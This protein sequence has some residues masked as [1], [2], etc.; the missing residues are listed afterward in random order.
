MFDKSL[1]MNKCQRPKYIVDVT[2]PDFPPCLNGYVV[3]S[4]DE[5]CNE[6]QKKGKREVLENKEF[7][8]EICSY[9]PD[10][11]IMFGRI[12]HSCCII[13]K[14]KECSLLQF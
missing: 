2:I 11:E 5:K 10:E 4:M 12:P 13:G 3:M 7:E 9:D 6:L 1:M 8:D 14:Y